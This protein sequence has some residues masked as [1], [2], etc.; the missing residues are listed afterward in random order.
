LISP[1]NSAR[2]IIAFPT[3]KLQVAMVT[4]IADTVY[5]FFTSFTD[6]LSAIPVTIATCNFNV[7]NAM[8][9]RAELQGE[10]KE[11]AQI[12]ILCYVT[13]ETGGR[14]SGSIKLI[15]GASYQ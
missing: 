10:I 5:S 6:N 12:N 1:C 11:P 7:G 13:N 9:G 8:M 4:G 3:L 14:R 15:D 2:P